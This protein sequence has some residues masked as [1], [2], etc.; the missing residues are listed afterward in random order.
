MKKDRMDEWKAVLK[1]T[2]FFN[3]FDD[4]E[5]I[6]I[7]TLSDIKKYDAQTRI[8]SE[9]DEDTSFHH[10]ILKGKV[11]ILK[12][13]VVIGKEN[14][15]AEINQGESFGEA[16]LLLNEPRAASVVAINEV[17]VLSIKKDDIE[18]WNLGMREKHY[19]QLAINLAK[20]LKRK[21]LENEVWVASNL[22]EN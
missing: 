13:S 11:A 16:G 4:A 15:I 2:A 12:N 17:Y 8:F 10:V 14:K 5:I 3:D 22:L 21:D 7:L 1:S 18:K 6:E 19:R 9:N 20:I